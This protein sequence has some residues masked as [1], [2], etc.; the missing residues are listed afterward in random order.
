MTNRPGKAEPKHDPRRAE[1]LEALVELYLRLN[2]YFC[3]RN[4]LQHRVS[5]FGLETESDLLAI[6]MPHQREVLED[7]W[8]QPNDKAL[9]LREDQ[10]LVDCVIAEVKDPSVEFNKSLRRADGVLRIVAG[11]RMFGIFPEDAFQK[12]GVAERL[13][14]DLH[15]QINENKWPE[16]PAVREP[17]HRLSVRMLVFAPETAKHA[18]ERAHFDLQR[19]LGFVGYRM[20]SGEPCAA[21][22]DPVVPSASPWRG[23][24]QLIVEVLDESHQAGKG[25]LQVADLVAGVLSRWPGS[26]GG[27]KDHARS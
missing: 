21:Y 23:C 3:I 17:G 14:S 4:Y 27:T 12:S 9:V 11:M 18:K 24:T 7:G 5:R 6:R 25:E 20:R 8:E 22:R 10:G 1:I 13:A 19:I 2:G 16:Y 26:G 15:R